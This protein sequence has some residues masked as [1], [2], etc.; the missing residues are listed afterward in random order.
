MTFDEWWE[1]DGSGFN[2]YR[3]KF[4]RN[5]G[6]DDLKDACLTAWQRSKG[7]N[8]PANKPDRAITC[9][10]DGYYQLFGVHRPGCPH[11]FDE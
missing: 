10:C 3:L 2:T 7:E 6:I 9:G 1:N 8:E 5:F 4:D 11:A